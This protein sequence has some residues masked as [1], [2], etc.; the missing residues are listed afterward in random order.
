MMLSHMRCFCCAT[1]AFGLI[2]S[3]AFGD[4]ISNLDSPSP[5]ERSTRVSLETGVFSPSEDPTT[6]ALNG[7][8]RPLDEILDDSHEMNAA[9]G[10]LL[11][12]PNDLF[13]QKTSASTNHHNLLIS[14]RAPSSGFSSIATSVRTDS[15]SL[16]SAWSD[17]DS[18]VKMS[19]GMRIPEP[20][21]IALLLIG[22]VG[23]SAGRRIRKSTFAYQSRN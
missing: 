22:V 4:A 5:W 9:T 12:K 11:A 13:D 6:L 16:A 17:S 20:G 23:W 21:S 19:H 7:F 3:N 10:R 14:A 1:L 8:Q 15:A 18:L 2:G